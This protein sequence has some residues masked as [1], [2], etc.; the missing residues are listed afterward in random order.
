MTK[1][2]E[3]HVHLLPGLDDSRPSLTVMPP[4]SRRSRPL[5]RALVAVVVI[6]LVGCGCLGR[7]INAP[8]PASDEVVV[9]D[10]GSEVP[11]AD[12][13]ASVT[14]PPDPRV[15]EGGEPGHTGWRTT[16]YWQ[17]QPI[18][19]VW[20]EPGSKYVHAVDFYGEEHKCNRVYLKKSQ[21][22]AR[23][24]CRVDQAWDSGWTRS[25]EVIF[26]LYIP[27]SDYQA[28]R[29]MVKGA[30]GTVTFK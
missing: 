4:R 1:E 16:N 7:Y 2:K 25:R 5:K 19:K 17:R 11:V 30:P 8:L 13:I 29:E 21:D 28:V 12:Y 26:T 15:K 18:V 10:D 9:L 24:S 6:A 22:T 23:A 27:D 14:P 20:R 3:V